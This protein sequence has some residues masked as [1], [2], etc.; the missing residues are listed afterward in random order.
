MFKNHS[1]TLRIGDPAPGFE[2]S[3]VEG[4]SVSLEHLR[5]SRSLVIF[6][7]GT[8]CPNCRKQMERLSR[9]WPEFTRRELSVV[10]IAA[11]KI[12]GLFGAQ[13]FVAEHPYPFPILF[14]ETREVTQSYGVYRLVGVDAFRIAHPAVFL[15]DPEL[16]IRWIAVSPNQSTRPSTEELI[17]AVDSHPLASS[18]AL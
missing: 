5:G 12:Q 13:K 2:L 3:T 10:L 9:D 7:R 4:N 1:D 18:T 6:L 15:L 16:K 11:Q 8:W 17:R 14:D